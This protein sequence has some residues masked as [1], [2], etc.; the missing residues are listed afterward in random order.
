MEKG[1]IA[2]YFLQLVLK[3]SEVEHILII[4]LLKGVLKKS[5]QEGYGTIS[6]SGAP[7]AQM[8]P[9]STTKGHH[10]REVPS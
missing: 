9:G 6:N 3:F 4:K 7:K 2:N 10:Q 8:F 5:N 1:R